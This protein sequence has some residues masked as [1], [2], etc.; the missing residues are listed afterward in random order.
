[1][2]PRQAA[3][4]TLL[5]YACAAAGVAYWLSGK[6]VDGRGAWFL[7]CV[8]RG[9]FGPLLHWR[10]SGKSPFPEDGPALIVANHRSPADPQILWMNHHFGWRHYKVR[11]ISFLTAK[12]FYER[13]GLVGWICRTMQSIPASRDGRDM[14]PARQA[15]R[16]LQQGRMVGVFPEG[17]INT[18]PGLLPASSG[19]AWLA[20]HADCPVIPVFIHDAPQ[21]KTMVRTFLTPSRT[22]VIYGSPVD[23]TAHRSRRRSHDVLDAVTELLMD[24][25]RELGGINGEV[26]PTRGA[27]CRDEPPARV[28]RPR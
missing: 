27:A 4:L 28:A 8:N 2:D 19:V 17:R 16:L 11:T 18:G 7:Y 5:F 3:Q 20:L 24:R 25:L 12:E 22:R 10:A 6:A 23:L 21:A 13:P 14:R 1:M 26:T 9:V 15:L